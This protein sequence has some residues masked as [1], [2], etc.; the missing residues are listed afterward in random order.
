M[1]ASMR[2]RTCKKHV[3][4]FNAEN[5]CTR[6]THPAYEIGIHPKK[7]ETHNENLRIAVIQG[8]PVKLKI[9][10]LRRRYIVRTIPCKRR[11]HIARYVLDEP[12]R[13]HGVACKQAIPE[14]DKCA[15]RRKP[16]TKAKLSHCAACLSIGFKCMQSL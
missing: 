11:T 9:V 16:E 15:R 10:I 2:M 3:F 14:Q 7:I 5:S 1:G 12:C 4:V 8:K 6:V 13:A